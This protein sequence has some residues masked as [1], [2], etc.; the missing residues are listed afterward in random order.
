MTTLAPL[1]QEDGQ[2][3]APDSAPVRVRVCSAC[4]ALHADTT[5][6]A[7]TDAAAG[8]PTETRAVHSSLFADRM[9]RNGY[10][11]LAHLATGVS[12]ARA[13]T[14][15]VAQADT[16]GGRRRCSMRPLSRYFTRTVG[17]GGVCVVIVLRLER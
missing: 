11:T 9:R 17:A 15:E 6:V 8:G 5:G 10:A 14:F 7:S 2:P 3:I 13:A 4:W 16:K 12:L 1:L